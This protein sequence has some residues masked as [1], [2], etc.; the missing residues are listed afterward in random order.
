MRTV[1]LIAL[2]GLLLLASACGGGGRKPPARTSATLA[3]AQCM[4]SNGVS[5]YPDPGSDGRLVKEPL[6]QLGVSGSTFESAQSA[7]RHLLP[8]GGEPPSVAQQQ[9]ARTQALAFS[10]CI[11][12]HGVPT[13]P[14]PDAT[15]RIPDPASVGIDQGSPTFE[16]ANDA[17]ARYRPPYVP[18]NSAYNAWARTHPN[19]S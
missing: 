18:S 12:A 19:G 17:C 14:D 16:A 9:R 5:K 3:F 11:R 6:G 13:F 4:R 2:S 10:G 8:N 15:G 1:A 7:C